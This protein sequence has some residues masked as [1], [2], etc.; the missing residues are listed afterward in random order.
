[1]NNPDLKI[2][3]ALLANYIEDPEDPDSNFKL[4]LYYHSIEQTASAVSFYLRTAERTDDKLLVYE[5]LLR[6]AMCFHTQGTRNDSVEGMLQHAVA[7]LPKRPEAY[8]HLSRFYEKTKKWF[9]GYLISS[10]GMSVA[11]KDPQDKLNTKIDYPGFWSLMFEKAVCSWWCG[12]CEESKNL[13][14]Y[15][16]FNETLDT[17]HRESTISNLKMLNSWPQESEINT[18]FKTKD[19]EINNS[20]YN[21]ELYLIKNK[22][23]LKYKFENYDTILRNYSET[24]QDMFVLTVLDGLKCGKW[25][26]IGCSYPIFASNTYLLENHFK[27]Q[28]ISID[29]QLKFVQ[30]M[31]L[32]RTCPSLILDATTCDYKK[33]MSDCNYQNDLD[34]LQVDCGDPEISLKALQKVISDGIRFKV[35]TFSHD[36]FNDKT[37]TVKQRSRQFLKDNGYLLFIS[38]VSHNDKDDY[39]DWYIDANKV[40]LSKIESLQMIDEQVKNVNKIFYL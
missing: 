15:L 40:D 38:N 12:L 31:H 30:K 9:H 13:F 11:E 26:E 20:V 19:E 1:M 34:Y 10:I 24:M 16:I 5:C 21:L 18:H 28:G 39:E 32:H 8:F 6:A 36:D 3:N 35:I 4:G 37:K 29:N 7:L 27:W 14:N 25:L 33:L 17:L 22:N 23:K 2:L